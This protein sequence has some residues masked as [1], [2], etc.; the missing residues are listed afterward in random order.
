MVALRFAELGSMTFQ[1]KML[2]SK[3]AVE[4]SIVLCILAS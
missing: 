1:D 2:A 3:R 4:G